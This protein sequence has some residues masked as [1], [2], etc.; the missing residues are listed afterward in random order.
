MGEDTCGH[1]FLWDGAGPHHVLP[2][3]GRLGWVLTRCL[4][5]GQPRPTRGGDRPRAEPGFEPGR[6]LLETPRFPGANSAVRPARI[7]G[8][9]FPNPPTRL[10]P[11]LGQPGAHR[12]LRSPETV[13]WPESHRGWG[14]QAA[15]SWGDGCVNSDTRACAHSRRRP[16]TAG[17]T[18]AWWL[19]LWVRVTAQRLLRAVDVGA[20]GLARGDPHSMDAGQGEPGRRAD[21]DSAPVADARFIHLQQAVMEHQGCTKK[22]RR[23][24][25]ASQA[26]ATGLALRGGRRMGSE[27]ADLWAVVL[28]GGTHAQSLLCTP[29]PARSYLPAAS[30]L[31][32]L[33]RGL[34]LCISFSLFLF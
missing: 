27:Q 28:F 2:T 23:P 1:G 4:Q 30:R 18:H 32:G 15:A 10:D 33:G 24:P 16:A 21:P 26:A 31:A 5:M 11:G 19:H 8:L 34:G 25:A 3:H 7:L 12:G 20:C 22:P 14:W 9:H 6:A 17:H 29:I 13:G